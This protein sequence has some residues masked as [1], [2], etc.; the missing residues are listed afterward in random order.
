MVE[1]DDVFADVLRI[2]LETDGRFV[3]VGRARDGAEAIELAKA[4][5]PD[6]VTMD[7]D[8]PRV[9]GVEATAAIVAADP[10]QRIVIVSGSVYGDRI[11]AAEEAGAVAFVRKARAVEEL[12]DVLFAAGGGDSAVTAA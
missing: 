5:A 11:R 2:L 9:D 6:V 8:M 1:D 4:L 7:V 10:S 12:A 3:V